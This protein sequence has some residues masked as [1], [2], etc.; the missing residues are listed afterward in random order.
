MSGLLYTILLSM[1][2]SYC[3]DARRLN[4]GLDA[5]GFQSLGR[6]YGRLIVVEI[7]FRFTAN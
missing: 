2:V 1:S 3:R 5:E 6:L 4:L 7:P